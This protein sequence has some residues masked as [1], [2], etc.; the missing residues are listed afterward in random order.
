MQANQP[1]PTLVALTPAEFEQLARDVF[2]LVQR[3]RIEAEIDVVA[4]TGK[5][6]SKVEQLEI[7]DLL[8]LYFAEVATRA[9]DAQMAP[10][11]LA[12]EE[13]RVWMHDHLRSAA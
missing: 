11:P 3:D 6:L 8:G 4:L 1:T 5:P 2:A 10:Q 9:V 7:K 13:M 12:L